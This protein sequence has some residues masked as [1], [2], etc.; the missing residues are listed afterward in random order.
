MGATKRTPRKRRGPGPDG[1]SPELRAQFYAMVCNGRN[2]LTDDDLAL[3]IRYLDA[4][5]AARKAKKATR[6]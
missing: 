2:E 5:H 6:K 4:E 1:P 3:A